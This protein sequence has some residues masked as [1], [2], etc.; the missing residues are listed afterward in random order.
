[1]VLHSL[2]FVHVPKIVH[3]TT[4]TDLKASLCHLLLL[5]SLLTK[6]QSAKL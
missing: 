1:M 5:S 6:L 4:I 3:F 2:L